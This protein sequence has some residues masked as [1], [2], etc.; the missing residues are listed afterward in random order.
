MFNTNTRKTKI[1][2]AGRTVIFV[3]DIPCHSSL[4]PRA[5]T[6]PQT[7]GRKTEVTHPALNVALLISFFQQQKLNGQTNNDPI[8]RKHDTK[9]CVVSGPAVFLRKRRESYFFLTPLCVRKPS[10]RQSFALPRSTPDPATNMHVGKHKRVFL[11]LQQTST[12]PHGE[13]LTHLQSELHRIIYG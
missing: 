11:L 3:A 5:I 1:H 13:A 7:P 9:L 4:L 2:T 10:M 12:V 8:L 6:A